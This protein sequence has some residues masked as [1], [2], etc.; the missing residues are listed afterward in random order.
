M[1]R[2]KKTTE[3][4]PMEKPSMLPEDY[5]DY[6]SA[7]IQYGSIKWQKANKMLCDGGEGSKESLPLSLEQVQ[8]LNM[9][10]AGIS[11]A[12][13]CKALK[14]SPAMPMLWEEEGEK[15]SL[16]SCC[17]DAIKRKQAV[18]LE[19]NMWE[20]AMVDNSS[21]RDIMK[22]FLIKPRMPEYKEN[23]PSAVVPVQ[24]NISIDGQPYVADTKM[25]GEDE[26]E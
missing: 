3:L 4:M 26:D 11:M 19:D 15:S 1:A 23:S 20:T 8:Y 5:C 22:M 17:V 2:V 16:F 14:I 18:M 25:V 21:R 12:D 10:M 9:R 13:A 24:V 7:L 6:G